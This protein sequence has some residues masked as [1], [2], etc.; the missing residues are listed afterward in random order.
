MTDETR[1]RHCDKPILA[2]TWNGKPDWTHAS[3]YFECSETSNTV[4]EPADPRPS[5]PVGEERWAKEIIDGIR[6]EWS[7]GCITLD[8]AEAKIAAALAALRTRL[9]REHSRRAE[10]LRC[11]EQNELD[12]AAETDEQRARAERAE[13]ALAAEREENA[14]LYGYREQD[15]LREAELGCRIQDLEAERDRLLI[16]LRT[17]ATAPD[18]DDLANAMRA[19]A[20]SALADRTEE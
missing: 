6:E 14:R 18:G 2:C 9:E 5:E 19:R 1:C 20:K 4:A 10:A 11:A 17:I 7:Q 15:V 13:A 16:A 12:A 3:G 8:H